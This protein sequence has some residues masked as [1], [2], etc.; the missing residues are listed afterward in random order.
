MIRPAKFSDIPAMMRIRSSVKENRLTD[1]AKV[2]PH[3]CREMLST[4]PGW[5]CEVHNTIV[6]FAIPDAQRGSVWALFVD[7]EHERK[8]IGR[9]LHDTMVE[10]L[11][12]AGNACIWLTTDP[13]TR[14]E[15]FYLAAGWQQAG[16][17][18][19][20]EIRFELTPQRFSRRTVL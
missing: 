15:R 6:G 19:E 16:V 11:F 14:A 9:R 1:P 17:T 12:A 5:V 13:D 10:W 3:H 8:G 2:Q 4:G 7:P 20:G 18:D